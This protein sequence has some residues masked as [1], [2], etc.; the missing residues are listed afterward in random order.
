MPPFSPNRMAGMPGLPARAGALFRVSVTIVTLTRNKAR[1]RQ[2]GGGVMSRYGPVWAQRQ[3]VTFDGARPHRK[4]DG[5]GA[6]PIARRAII[7]PSNDA[8][9][10]SPTT[11]WI[12]EGLPTKD[13]A[14]VYALESAQPDL[15][16]LDRTVSGASFNQFDDRIDIISPGKWGGTS[17]TESEERPIGLLERRSQKRNF[18]LAQTLTWSK[19]VEGVGAGV[20]RSIA[21]C[22]SAG[23]PEPVVVTDEHMV[24]VTIFPRPSPEPERPVRGRS[25]LPRYREIADDLRYQIESGALSAEDKLPSETDLRDEYAASR[26]TIRDAIKMLISQGLIETRPGEGTF[27]RKEIEP[28]VISL[29]H[30]PGRGEDAWSWLSA[31]RDQNRNPE[32]TVPRVA[33][34]SESKLSELRDLGQIVSRYREFYADGIPWGLQTEYFPLDTVARVA[35]RLLMAEDITDGTYRYLLES[36]GIERIRSRHQ[37]LVRLPNDTEAMY[38]NLASRGDVAIMEVR[39]T[40]FAPDDT[41]IRVVITILPSDRNVVMM[42]A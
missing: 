23:A 33:V 17:V 22:E 19:L 31:A 30:D 28:L 3:H 36:L 29:N 12:P 25:G 24:Q 39:H 15:P 8:R 7:R 13:D 16:Y 40:D 6:V 11:G 1:I 32:M 35:T 4:F 2:D 9:D 42:D 26:N 37:I 27:V 5:A 18:R 34:S 20:P 14:V 21:D 38:F 10:D 41:V